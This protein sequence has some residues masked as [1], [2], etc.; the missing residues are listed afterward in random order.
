MTRD[1]QLLDRHRRGEPVTPGDVVA[2]ITCRAELEAWR[3]ELARQ[4]RYD[5]EAARA[6]SHRWQELRL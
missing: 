3:A 6:F 4:G 2:T 5:T 1:R